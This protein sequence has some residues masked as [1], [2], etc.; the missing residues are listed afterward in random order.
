[1]TPAR[2]ALLKRNKEKRRAE[3]RC[4]CCGGRPA[5]PG[6]E[7]CDH[8]GGREARTRERERADVARSERARKMGLTHEQRIA[9]ECTRCTSVAVRDGLCQRHLDIELDPAIIAY[10]RQVRAEG[11]DVEL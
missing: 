11:G 3:G 2:R 7:T 1:M 9:L 6:F 4:V 5:R 8:C 10:R